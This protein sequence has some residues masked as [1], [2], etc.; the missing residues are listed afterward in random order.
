LE[1]FEEFKL[2]VKNDYWKHSCRSLI[3]KLII[4][5]VLIGTAGFAGCVKES[6]STYVRDDKVYG[7]VKGTFRHRWWNYYER[8]L[9]FTEGEFFKEAAADL[10]KAIDQRSNDQRMARTYGMHFVDYFPHR[11]LGIVYYQMGNLEAA[12]REL[13]L[14]IG[15]FSSAKALFYLDRIRK[16][17]IEK[18]GQTV[19][20]PKL[21]LDVA[22]DEIRTRDDPVTISGT[23]QDDHF[24]SGVSIQGVP[25]FLE[26][27]QKTFAFKEKLA[28]SQGKHTIEI[29]AENLIGKVAKRSLTIHV[30][31]EGPVITIA[32]FKSLSKDTRAKVAISGS[33]YDDSGIS[34][35]KINGQSIAVGKGTDILFSR[36]LVPDN[37]YLELTARDRLGNQTSATIPLARATVA[38]MPVMLAGIAADTNDLFLA[39]LFGP[40]DNRPPTINL[41]GW[42]GT[43]TV[44]LKKIYIEGE[45]SDESKI[46]SL[47]IN[48]IPVM[49]REGTSIFFGHLAELKKGSNDFLIEARDARGNTAS[50]TISVTRQIPKA[51]QL[52]ERLS[53]SIL[54]FEQKGEIS[55]HSTA[56]QDN[57]TNA[58]V[59]LNRFRIVERDKLDVVLQEQKLSRT[60]LV[61]RKTALKLGRL[62]AAR[63][64]ITGSI[65]ETRTGIEIVARLIDTETSEILDTEDVYDEVKDLRALKTLSEGMAV[66]FHQDFPLL[67]GVVIHQKGKYIFTDL[68]TDKIKVQRRL[69]VYREEAFTDPATGK[70]LGAD[71]VILGHARVTQVMPKMSK[72]EILADNDVPVKRLDKVIT[73]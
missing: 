7:T 42:A 37:N 44:F 11:E 24:I 13:A 55:E 54:P 39:G 30:D 40:A 59:N 52:E 57:L 4:L 56:F 65:I 20:P 69:I 51:L 14:S 70:V 5:A 25:L 64:I 2:M 9:S 31:R 45:V 35:L 58:L 19:A 61:D 23:A 27:S 67:G 29:L 16:E 6:A 66:K 26:G 22:N 53:I 46:V 50:K 38:K 33:V 17:I 12:K 18:K 1:G 60:K 8:G 3:R 15:Q 43:Q 72:A 48:K 49:R 10:Q 63:S 34:E 71:N 21:S 41:K 28:L 68:G 36:K 73:E 32:E 47:A 62:V